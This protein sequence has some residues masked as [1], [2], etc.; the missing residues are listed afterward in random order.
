VRIEGLFELMGQGAFVACCGCLLT[1][2]LHFDE[3]VVLQRL[4]NMLTHRLL[5]PVL[6]DL[7]TRFDAVGK[8]SQS[9]ALFWR[10]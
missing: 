5:Q 10:E 9:F 3:L 1:N 8:A 4:S 6:A 7:H 2:H